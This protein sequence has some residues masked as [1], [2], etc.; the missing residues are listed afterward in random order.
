MKKLFGLCLLLIVGVGISS[1]QTYKNLSFE[2][3]PIGFASVNILG[4]N[5]TTGGVGG[6]TVQISDYNSLVTDIATRVKTNKKAVVYVINGTITGSAQIEC[7]GVN[8]ITFIGK[9]TDA[10]MT[11]VG[12]HICNAS[13]I[14]VR[15]IRFQNCKP[16]CITV[17]TTSSSQTHHVWIDHCTFSDDPEVDLSS[18]GT[19]DGLLDITHRSNYCTVS[20]CEFHN[21][22]KVCLLGYSDN[23]TDETD[24]L[25]TTY[26]HNWWNNT[27]QRHPR[28]RHTLCH[29]FDNYYDGSNTP[30]GQIGMGN[31]LQSIGYGITSTCEADLLVE[32]N[33][34]D[35]VYHPTEIGQDNSVA[36]D[37]VERYNFTNLGPILT[38]STH[39]TPFEASTY[40]TYSLDSV[41]NVPSIVKAGAGAGKLGISTDV[42]ENNGGKP[43]SFNLSQNFPNPFNPSTVINYQLQKSSFVTLKIY[44]GIGQEVASLVNGLQ[45]AGNYTS[46]F[47]AAN[48]PS[49]LYFYTLNTSSASQTKKM[50]LI[51]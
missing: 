33:Y 43:A 31:D 3:S 44:N 45:E 22:D 6:D 36:G 17:N 38:R 2:N 16:D 32:A 14:I 12:I 34:F 51:K 26:H 19:H 30:A 40:Y 46:I 37:L 7:K 29:V 9:G 13:N 50:M 8:N 18:S 5:G 15:N 41:A 49:G 47:N 1:G 39:T 25:R 23:A 42:K 28:V 24:Q 27:V 20:W 48:L 10:T 21:H 35:H 11:G 4:Q